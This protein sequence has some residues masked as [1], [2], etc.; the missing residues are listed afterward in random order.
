MPHLIQTLAQTKQIHLRQAQL[1]PL[2]ANNNVKPLSTSLAGPSF[3]QKS[4]PDAANTAIYLFQDTVASSFPVEELVV[5]FSALNK[6][7]KAKI[8]LRI[9]THNRAKWMQYEIKKILATRCYLSISSGTLA[10]TY[11]IFYFPSHVINHF[12]FFF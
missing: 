1:N 4:D 5:G 11:F 2:F 3:P 10:I 6:P 9:D 8:F 7:S 12:S